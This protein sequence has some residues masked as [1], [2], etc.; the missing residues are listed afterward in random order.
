MRDYKLLLS[1]LILILLTIFAG[2]FTWLWTSNLKNTNP[3]P[4]MV[5]EY[6]EV[7]AETADDS[8]TITNST[9]HIQAA[10]ELK[11]ALDNVIVHFES[12]YPRVQMTAHYVS[13]DELLTLS[14]VSTPDNQ[15]SRYIVDIDLIIANNKLT[16]T[17]LTPLQT[18][19]ND[20]QADFNERQLNSVVQV[21]DAESVEGATLWD[22]TQARN[23]TSFSYAI[24]DSQAVDGVIL[25]DNPVAITFRNFLLSSTGQDILKKY[26]YD[27]IDGYKNSVADLFNPT[28]QAKS[29]KGKESESVAD[30]LSN[31]K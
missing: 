13:A 21:D 18:L 7:L 17:Q 3:L 20:A 25:T 9:L 5:N 6:S 2:V 19:L 31:G 1:G 4:V 27:N 15:S 14:N 22:T 29:A 26:S 28:S 10:D 11:V 16:R 12:R 24:K 23:L 8:D 30:A